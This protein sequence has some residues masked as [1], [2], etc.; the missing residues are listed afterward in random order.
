MGKV[1]IKKCNCRVQDRHRFQSSTK[2]EKKK[3]PETLRKG[4][5][6]NDA[7]VTFRITVARRGAKS[8]DP[9]GR[10]PIKTQAQVRLNIE[11]F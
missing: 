3:K 2:G 5:K 8:R 6:S 1:G 7:S 4:R 9:G 10:K 11:K